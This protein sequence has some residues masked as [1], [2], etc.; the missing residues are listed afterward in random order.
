MWRAAGILGLLALPAQ[1]GEYVATTGLLTDDDFYRLVACGA[2]PGGACTKPLIRWDTLSPLRVAIARID[3]AYLGGRQMRARAAL[4][5]A[6][7]YLNDAG[8]GLRLVITDDPGHAHIRIYL[9][10]TDGSTPVSGS[11]L[12]T[13]EG[14]TIRGATVRVWWTNRHEITRAIIAFSTN[15]SIRQY[16]SA[17]LEEV[18][19]AL[20]FMTDI[21]NPAYDGVSVF[22][23]D[24]N[25]AKTL[26]PQDIMA[27]RRHYPMQERP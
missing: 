19:Q 23:E 20:G 10:D 14:A 16:E 21:R 3:R 7:Q 9:L 27:L 15:L 24:S 18:T 6:V 25:A 5:R 12:D 22:S 17:M 8:A 13:I 1:A 26:G 11:G 2:A 4:I